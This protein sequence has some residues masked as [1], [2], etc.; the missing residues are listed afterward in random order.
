MQESGVVSDMSSSGLKPFTAAEKHCGVCEHMYF[1]GE[2]NRPPY[3]TKHE[4]TT[5][6]TVGDVCSAFSL[7]SD[8]EPAAVELD[9]DIEIDWA[10]ST[11]GTEGPFYPA[12]ADGEKYGLLCGNCETVDVA[13]GPMGRFI[14]NRCENTHKPMD[15]DRAYL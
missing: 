9:V 1:R 12:Y 5:S 14:C 7:R 15:W 10:E 8:L 11:N 4:Q 13:V 2:W 3:C 6:I